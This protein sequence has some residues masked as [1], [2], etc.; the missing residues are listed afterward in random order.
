MLKSE[1]IHGLDVILV[2]ATCG[3]QGPDPEPD[4][5]GPSDLD[6]MPTMVF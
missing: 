3:V 6:W 4:T 1:S 5:D 2:R